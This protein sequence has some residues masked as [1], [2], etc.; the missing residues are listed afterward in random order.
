MAISVGTVSNGPRQFNAG[1]TRAHI[2]DVGDNRVLLVWVFTG[3][4]TGHDVTAISYGGVNILANV[5]IDRLNPAGGDART[6][7]FYMIA[8]PAGPANVVYTLTGNC[9]NAC[10][11]QAWVGVDPEDAFGVPI[12]DIGNTNLITV[13]VGSAANEVV[14][15]GGCFDGGGALVITLGAGQTQ[16]ARENSAAGADLGYGSSYE[17]GA[18][19]NVMTWGL[20]AVRQ[21]ATGAVA[22]RPFIPFASRLYEYEFNV[23]DPL[24]RLIGRDGHEV[25]PNE[26]RADKWGKLLGFRS[27]SS[28]VYASLADSPDAF[29]ISGVTSDG[30]MVRITPDEKLFADMILKRITR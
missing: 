20:A 11:A 30:K 8:P 25:A 3:G 18:A 15:D 24:Q 1:R 9:M 29:Y 7:C 16:L 28:K 23:W 10:S 6:H 2:T 5:L 4:S 26:V 27:P 22:L 19:A 21:W 13:T 17:V 14:V 12:T